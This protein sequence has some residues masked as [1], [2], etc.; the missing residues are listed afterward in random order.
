MEHPAA[1]QFPATNGLIVR[2]I[3]PPAR[4]VLLE[5]QIL[6]AATDRE[7]SLAVRGAVLQRLGIDTGLRVNGTRLPVRTLLHH[8]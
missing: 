3:R 7:Q 4:P 6:A 8:H 2:S 1:R 5:Y